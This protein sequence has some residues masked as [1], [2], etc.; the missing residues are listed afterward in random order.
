MKNSLVLAINGG[1]TWLSANSMSKDKRKY[2][3]E[4]K[5]INF[6]K[7]FKRP[8]DLILKRNIQRVIYLVNKEQTAGLFNS[9][10]H[11]NVNFPLVSSQAK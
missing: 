5:F 6:R 11:W 1:I 9:P 3:N 8:F 4:V 2:R 7:L 10:D